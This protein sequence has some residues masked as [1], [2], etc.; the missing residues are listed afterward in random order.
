MGH[1]SVANLSRI[2]LRRIYAKGYTSIR[3]C[4]DIAEK[5]GEVFSAS[6][7]DYKERYMLGMGFYEILNYYA[8]EYLMLG[9]KRGDH[10]PVVRVRNY[11]SLSELQKKLYEEFIT[12][13]YGDWDG[14]DDG[15][16]NEIGAFDSIEWE[17][18]SVARRNYSKL[19]VFNNFTN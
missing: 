2:F 10:F 5:K 6:E 9:N 7:G 1:A 18:L 4:V 3:E 11:E 14:G 15:E 19:N 17:F 16:S 12:N 8:R 13:G